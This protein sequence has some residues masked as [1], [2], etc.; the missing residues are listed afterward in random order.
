MSQI[1]IDQDELK[2]L[3]CRAYEAG[4]HGTKELK[5]EAVED[6]LKTVPPPRHHLSEG[7]HSDLYGGR[8]MT[9]DLDSPIT[10]SGGIPDQIVISHDQIPDQ[11]VLSPDAWRN[12]G[13]G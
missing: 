9:F 3:L 7:L 2:K 12:A 6:L 4:W 1:T 8:T 10:I 13:D 5:E 11:I